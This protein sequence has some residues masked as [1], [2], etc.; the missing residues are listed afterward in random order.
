LKFLKTGN[1]GLYTGFSI[2]SG[3]IWVKIVL[4]K[5]FGDFL[6]ENANFTAF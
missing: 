4:G 6:P 2:S 1:T 3:R 5:F